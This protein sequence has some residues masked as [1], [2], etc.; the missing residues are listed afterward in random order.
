MN[1]LRSLPSA[2]VAAALAGILGATSRADEHL[3][4]ARADRIVSVDQGWGQLGLDTAV[5]PMDRPAEKLRI[6]DKPYERGL[7]HHAP[8]EIVVDLGGQFTT[9]RADV[10]VQWQG[11]GAAGSVVFRVFVDNHEVFASGVMRQSDPPRPVDVS[12]EGA[13]EL[14]LVCEE[15]G[16]GIAC[17]CANWADARLTR[18]PKAADRPRE[19]G[20]DVAPFGYIVAW[21]PKHMTGTAASRIEEFPAEDLY[22]AKDLL[23]G[24]DGAYRAAVFDGAASI[25]VR[26]D[27]NRLLRQLTLELADPASAPADARLQLWEGES[28]WQGAWR[29]LDIKPEKA[30]NRLTWR[31]GFA[32]FPR[33]TQK[34]RWVFPGATE[35]IVVKT[36]SAYTRSTWR[37]LD[38]RIES[39]RPAAGQKATVDL[40][41]GVL[42]DAAGGATRECAWNPDEPL[43]VKVRHSVPKR[44]KAD[45]TVLRFRLPEAVFAV[46]VEDLLANDCVYVPH[47][48]VF[49][50][51]LPAPVTS[52]EYLARIAGRKTMLQ[53]VRQRPDQTFARAMEVVHNPV[54]DRGPTMLS[55]ACDNRKFVVH[56]VGRV[57]FDLCDRPDGE[58]RAFPQQWLLVPRFGGGTNQQLARRLHGGWLPM[59]EITVT[60]G[61]VTYR[62][63]AYVAP[64]G[65]PAAGKPAWWRDRALGVVEYEIANRGAEPA[66]VDF[67]L[68]FVPGPAPPAGVA[69][70]ASDAA[71]GIQVVAGDRVAAWID[72]RAAGPLTIKRDGLV[73]TLAAALPAGTKARCTVLLP[74]W[75][76][77]VGE[78][79]TLA[80]PAPWA[81]RTEAYWRELLAPAMQIELPDALL[82]NVIR[83]S[84]VHCLLAARNEDGGA[85]IAPWISSPLYGP[86]ESEANAILRGMDMLGH[87]DFARRG[88]DFFI[89]RFNEAGFLTT[90]YTLVG[91][92]EHLWTLA[93]HHQ[94]TADRA[95]LAQRAANL[96]RTCQWVIRQRAKTQRTDARGHN[97]P[98]YGLMPPGVSADWNR[99]AYRFFNDAQYY[100][101]LETAGRAL[102]DVGHP[103]AEAILAD[104]RRY[105]EDIVR[106]YR[107]TQARSPVVPL[108]DGA[109]APADPAILDCFG[110][111]EDF[112]PDEDAN[113][114]WCYSIEIGAH[115][116]A[117]TGILDPASDEV[118]WIAD[119]LEDVQFLR[120]GM[121]DYPEERNRTDPFC[122]G[123]FSKV[124]PY[125]CRI[126]EVYALRDDVKPFVRSYFNAIPTLLNPED[127]SFWEHFHNM[128][129]WNKTHETGWFLCQTALML[130]DARGDELWLAPMATDQWFRDGMTISVGNAPTRFGPVGYTIAS[131]VAQG[132]IDAEILPP[133]RAR[134]ARI[135]LRVRH[136]EG[137]PIQRVVVNGQAHRDFDP[138]R[139]IVRLAP[140]DEPIRVRVQF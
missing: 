109:W 28:A 26:W 64:V 37:D 122:F 138:A 136:P 67:A 10:G 35:P 100:A 7:G 50:T 76:L 45:R 21:D 19:P 54:Q 43:T 92:G 99:F 16:D 125:Y 2:V 110:R 119:H 95:W 120:T 78:I 17:D 79:A 29:P 94:R 72:T 74:A 56:R 47:A 137:K 114:S 113:R 32:D 105:R 42:F 44:Y 57:D 91:T 83:A 15:A 77:A 123:G 5:K 55:L 106:A 48:G 121:G 73:V 124:Q 8:G 86:L 104:A 41:N 30:G 69:L 34:A 81:E 140:S 71:G 60:E 130:V 63:T 98:E 88:F 24:D 51:R 33:G 9:F 80:E 133:R 97:V 1:I 49:V 84:Q 126:A 118:G 82:T 52:K 27:E 89:K 6:G 85:R 62:Q 61:N 66:E 12:V 53:R 14:R 139:A 112:L 38:V 128:G 115:Q 117:A 65:E 75:P 90:G 116:L 39:T 59:P 134:P 22:P 127:L 101:G 111:V 70:E 18:D 96:A 87:A 3:S 132:H 25:G 46:A 58:P 103:D 93:E 4:D 31:L 11:G 20:V 13:N 135:V 107:W 102:A 131:S 23:P 36:L 108:D 129:A 40:Y 68:N